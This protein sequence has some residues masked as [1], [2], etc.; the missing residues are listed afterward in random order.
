[1][2]GMTHNFARRARLAAIVMA[3]AVALLTAVTACAQPGGAG[4]NTSAAAA[5]P[6]PPLDSVLARASAGRQKGP[7]D[8]KVTVI[9]VSDFQCPYCRMFYDST[10]R[11]FDSAYVKTGRVRMVYVNYPL[12]MH[13]QAF[14]AAK[15]AMCAGAQG[16]F[17]QMHDLLF[18]RQGEWADQADAPQRF[19]RFA[20]EVGVNAAQFRDCYDN[21]RVSPLITYD[22][23]QATGAGVNST[24]TFIINREKILPGA[25][26]Y[27]DLAR[28][29]DAAIAAAQN[30]PRPPGSTP[31]TTPPAAPP[32]P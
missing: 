24:P 5:G 12:P 10:Y 17:W 4:G 21:D 9:E 14:A 6:L 15:A 19:T 29:V 31:P 7:R 1:M 23:T 32:R 26:P 13:N 2:N 30:A 18:G 25:V 28:E 16:R 8:A 20:T 11:R 27:A 3:G 22:L